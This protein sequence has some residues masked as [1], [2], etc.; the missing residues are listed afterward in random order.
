M[1]E[2]KYHNDAPMLKYLQKIFNSCCFSSLASE[3]VIIKQTKAANAISLRIEESLK[4]KMGNRID[5]ANAI[6]KKEK[7]FNGNQ[8][9]II[10]QGNIKK[11]IL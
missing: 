9:C 8:K 10:N 3:F 7:K 4:S 5:F 1:E 2:F 6:L 11:E